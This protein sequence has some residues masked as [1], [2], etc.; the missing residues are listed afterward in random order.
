[1][2]KVENYEKRYK[3]VSMLAENTLN[4]VELNR[5]IIKGVDILAGNG[6]ALKNL[7]IRHGKTL[8]II[9]NNYSLFQNIFITLFLRSD[10]N[11]IG[12]L[13]SFWWRNFAITRYYTEGHERSDQLECDPPMGLELCQHNSISS[14]WTV[15]HDVW[16]GSSRIKNRSSTSKLHK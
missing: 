7:T 13:R 8:I 1:M 10:N 15:H 9:I 5:N 6:E 4:I 16:F 14:R 12:K 3:M 11:N 2:R